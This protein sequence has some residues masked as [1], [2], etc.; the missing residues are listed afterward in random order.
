MENKEWFSTE[1]VP[2]SYSPILVKW[3]TGRM[4]QKVDDAYSISDEYWFSEVALWRYY[5]PEDD[6]LLEPIELLDVSEEL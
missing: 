6:A 5:T 1:I 3:K 4:I 2:K